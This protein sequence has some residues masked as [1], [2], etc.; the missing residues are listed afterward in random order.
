MPG[1]PIFLCKNKNKVF[2]MK[3]YEDLL[4]LGCFTFKKIIEIT[5]SEAA[6][7]WLVMEYQKKRSNRAG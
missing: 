7:K 5:G 3:Y 4:I 6:A 1:K 2:I